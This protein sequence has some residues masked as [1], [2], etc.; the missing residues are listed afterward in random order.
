MELS[1]L[2]I[3]RVTARRPS[4]DLQ[5]RFALYVLARLP[6]G[7]FVLDFDDLSRWLRVAGDAHDSAP[8]PT[9]RRWW[10]GR[11]RGGFGDTS[12]HRTDA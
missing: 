3:S 11:L 7:G 6:N 9:I 12:S 2:L 5:T 1:R 8:T 4:R 10:L